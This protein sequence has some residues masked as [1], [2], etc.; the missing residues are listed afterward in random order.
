M[1]N[2]IGR[3]IPQ[4]VDGIDNIVPYQGEWAIVNSIKSGSSFKA[5]QALKVKPVDHVK[6]C[7]NLEE[8]LDK[9]E[10]HDGMTISFHHHMRG[11]DG[12][13]VPVI[14]SLAKRGL[15]DITLASS[16]LTGAHEPLVPYVEDGTITR[17][18]TSGCR[19]KLGKA[20]SAGKLKKVAVFHSHGGRARAIEAGRIKIDV[21]FISAA[22]ADEAG[23]ATGSWGKS[24]CGSLGY[25]MIDSEYSRQVV[26]VTDNLVE[27]PCLPSSIKQKD[28]D[29]VVKIDSIGD[30][31]KIAGDTTRITKNPMDLRIAD[32]AA[33]AMI[34]LGYV[35]NG[36][37]F[38]CGAGG[39]SLAVARF[40]C[41]YMRKKDI[42]GGFLL[43]GITSVMTDMLEE[44]LFDL[45]FDVQSF[46]AAVSKSIYGNEKHIEI[47]ASQYA[48]PLN[49]DCM[50]HKLDTVVLAALEIDTDFNVNVLVG[51]DGNIRGAS[52]GHSDTA[53]GASLTV[54]VAPSIRGR[55]PIV[56]KNIHTVVTPG[57]SVDLLV[58]EKGI[59]INPL[60]QDLKD[61]LEGSGLPIRDINELAEEVERICGKPEEPEFEDK[62][63]AVVEYRDGSIIDVIRKVK[64]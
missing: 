4:S 41:D 5:P 29:Y 60:R 46:D 6:V 34:K 44:G 57:A 26:V 10:L 53:A 52:G 8:C 2:S 61:K 18:F 55:L 45:A 50:T 22:A 31:E 16:S 25:A 1:K 54:L 12:T 23:N 11:G 56:K 30:P 58:T 38:Q 32:L 13:I 47:S 42:K 3:E 64:S 27:Y 14:E 21:S 7:D 39:A 15:K 19:G 37:S 24:A 17:I 40:I 49:C 63:V 51:S 36:F 59:C 35:K 43:G 33:E 28:V 62:V 48:N 20:V 9:L